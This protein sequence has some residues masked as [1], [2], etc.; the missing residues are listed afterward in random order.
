MIPTENKNT[1]H[2]EQRLLPKCL[3]HDLEIVTFTGKRKKIKSG[4]FIATPRNITL[5]IVLIESIISGIMIIR[6]LLLETPSPGTDSI[7]D[8]L[9]TTTRKL[10]HLYRSVTRCF[11]YS[12]KCSIIVII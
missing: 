3:P 6:Y 12:F 7:C 9:G 10:I 11:C 8:C 2:F 1:I 4:Y 5:H